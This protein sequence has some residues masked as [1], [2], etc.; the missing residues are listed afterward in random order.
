MAPCMWAIYTGEDDLAMPW[1]INVMEDG[2]LRLQSPNPKIPEKIIPS[3]LTRAM[4][5]IVS[6]IF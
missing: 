4:D 1:W 6:V 2:K 5:R 3:H